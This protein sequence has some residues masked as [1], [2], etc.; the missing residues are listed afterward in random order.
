MSSK[1]MRDSNGTK[2]PVLIW[3]FNALLIV[4]VI[5]TFIRF[6]SL[7]SIDGFQYVY[8][9]LG[10]VIIVNIPLCYAIIK[11]KPWAR[12]LAIA[13]CL[14]SFVLAVSGMNFY[15]PATFIEP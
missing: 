4:G 9:E 14:I 6:L 15:N 8:F 10:F 5:F 1:V 12:L 7:V 3:I 11:R 2:M 13:V